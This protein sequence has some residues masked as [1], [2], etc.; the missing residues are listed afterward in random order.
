MF[1]N[2]FSKLQKAPQLSKKDILL[3]LLPAIGL[4]FMLLYARP[5]LY[6]LQCLDAPGVCTKSGVFDPDQYAFK[7][8]EVPYKERAHAK[9]TTNTIQSAS[10]TLVVAIPAT[11]HAASVFLGR[12]NPATAWIFF[13]TDFAIFFEAALWNSF[14]KEIV[15]FI[16]QRP[17]PNI[18]LKPER[19]GYK[20]SAYTSFYSGHTSFVS[21]ALTSLILILLSRGVPL[22]LINI[23]SVLS[24]GAAATT[25]YLRIVC[26]RHFPTDVITGLIAG[27]LIAIALAVI[28]QR[29]KS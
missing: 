27:I 29:K 25:G 8:L 14:I 2:L 6:K 20:A 5:N 3:I 19:K 9:Y 28:H 1:Q 11:L 24:F 12:I 23:L 26:Q 17:R 22:F 7:F 16:S 10:A 13:A 15:N 4:A 21:L 18:Y